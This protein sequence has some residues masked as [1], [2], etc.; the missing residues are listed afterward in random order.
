MKTLIA[1]ALALSTFAAQADEW[2]TEQKT[3]AAVGMTAT[4]IDYGQTRYIASKPYL[5]EYNPIMGRHPS[6]GRIAANF[7]I[8]P[9]LAYVIADN[10]SSEHRTMFLY[11][12]STIEVGMVGRN[13]YLGF[14]VKF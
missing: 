12:V 4:V 3:I 9:L 5:H 6:N 1:V 13:A 2:T 14:G 10:L 11:T 8:M 7:I